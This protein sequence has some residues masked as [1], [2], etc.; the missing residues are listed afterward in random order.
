MESR[1][2]VCRIK[3][4]DADLNKKVFDEKAILIRV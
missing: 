4:V 3:K 2:I 1:K